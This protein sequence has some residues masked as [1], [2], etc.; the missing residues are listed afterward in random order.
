MTYDA[1]VNAIGPF[2]LSEYLGLL[3]VYIA[4]AFHGPSPRPRSVD[5]R[6]GLAPPT[7]ERCQSAIPVSPSPAT[8]ELSFRPDNVLDQHSSYARV[9]TARVRDTGGKITAQLRL[10]SARS[11][12]LAS[13]RDARRAGT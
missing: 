8:R 6:N 12:T 1:T 10:Q 5:C 4:L 9:V 2:E 11:A 7:C 13:M 3:L